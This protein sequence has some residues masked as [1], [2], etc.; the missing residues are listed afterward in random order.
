MILGSGTGVPSAGRGAPGVA[1]KVG[2]KWL[3]IDSGSGTL[4]R[5]TRAGIDY[6]YLDYVLY[7]HI[8]TDHTADLAPLL[9]AMNHTP[10]FA[11]EREL[12]IIGPEGFSRF[13]EELSRPYPW[14]K[15]RGYRLT[16][17]EV[18]DS[19]F[20]LGEIQMKSAPVKHGSGAAVSYRINTQK[21]ESVVVSGD[22]SFCESIVDLAKGTTLLVL[23]A[24]VPEEKLNNGNHLT[25]VQ[26]GLIA[27]LADVNNLVLYHFYPACDEVD[28]RALCANEYG[29]SIVLAEDFM[30]VTID[31]DTFI[32]HM[33]TKED[34]ETPP[35]E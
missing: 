21:G 34:E 25:P 14:I 4:Q 13:V 35:R 31:G 29:G 8:H 5:M 7:T 15:P 18:S 33:P 19:C 22:T 26:A 12:T 30:E 27:R 24:S 28:M 6:R 3:L 2:E 1:V 9:F 17:K 32:C 20:S 10:G 16:L 11:R 23:E